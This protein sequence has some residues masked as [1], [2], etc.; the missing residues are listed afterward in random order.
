MNLEQ[1]LAWIR[2]NCKDVDIR[3]LVD[4]MAQGNLESRKQRADLVR[5]ESAG[6]M[7]PSM[8]WEISRWG[9][10]DDLSLCEEIRE[11]S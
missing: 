5:R 9:I 8:L 10:N 7:P 1:V 11:A 2:D 6:A 4:D 3:A